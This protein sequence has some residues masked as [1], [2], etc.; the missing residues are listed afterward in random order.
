VDNE[1]SRRRRALA[2]V[3][4]LVVVVVV[5]GGV[6]LGLLILSRGS[7]R[8]RQHG[9]TVS[10]SPPPS[11]SLSPLPSGA[12]PPAPAGP[13]AQPAPT[14]QQ[15]GVSVNRL[16]NDFTYSRQQIDAQ[17]QALQRTGATIAR[18][19]A[20]WELAE[21]AAPTGG[22]HR[23]DWRFDDALVGAL[24][25]HR[26]GWLPI[27]DYTAAWAQSVPGQDHS[28]PRS[29]GDYAAFAAA[30]AARYGPGGSFWRAHLQ[31]PALPV[32]TY[33]IWN[34]PDN[35]EFWVP[36]PDPSG[37]AELYLRARDTI[38]AVQP[39]ARVLVGGLTN[40]GDRYP[41]G[42]L[43]LM[44]RARPDLAGHVDGVAIHPYAPTPGGVLS[45]VRT[46]R[47]ALKALG[48]AAVPL[49]VTEFGWST[50]PA[51]TLNWAPE[52]L[53]PGYISR[54]LVTLAHTDCKVAAAVLY[55]WVTPAVDPAN[56]EDWYGIAPVRGGPSLD[57]DAFAAGLRAAALPGPS[58]T[59]C[60]GGG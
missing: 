40:L 10:V 33:E 7:A 51:H 8:H 42:F 55:T 5:M 36:E 24:A 6:A 30:L 53:R 15:F 47:R 12:V 29:P 28:P 17:L 37:Y 13:P 3:P 18:S 52:T 60:A 56:R 54:T 16:F 32:G 46:A 9:R 2:A 11:R 25:A 49:Y 43:A 58:G 57:V 45:R 59:L 27:I 39:S 4:V 41:A 1:D 50:H 31:L 19:D 23:Y 22:V 14:Q 20:F 34:E 48:L 44:V 35:P 38:T 26:L 21:P